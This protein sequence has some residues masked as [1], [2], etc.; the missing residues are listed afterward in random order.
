MYFGN[1]WRTLKHMFFRVKFTTLPSCTVALNAVTLL[2]DSE[3]LCSTA[4][5]HHNRQVWVLSIGYI[6]F[7]VCMKHCNSVMDVASVRRLYL[8]PVI[9]NLKIKWQ[10]LK[11][12]LHCGFRRYL[13]CFHWD[14]GA[15]SMMTFSL[16]YS[17]FVWVVTCITA[18]RLMKI[19]WLSCS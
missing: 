9:H 6:N 10:A 15:L 4:S 12:L 16:F 13:V 8:N 18:I 7:Y 14:I 2:A 5:V 19:Q 17:L 1:K 3:A 11:N